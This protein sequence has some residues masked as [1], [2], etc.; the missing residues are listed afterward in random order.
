GAI[1]Q[2]SPNISYDSNTRPIQINQINNRFDI[3]TGALDDVS[4]PS[5]L[6]V[7]GESRSQ[8]SMPDSIEALSRSNVRFQVSLV[9]QIFYQDVERFLAMLTR[10]F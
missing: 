5:G 6:S 9:F 4:L 8:P 7:I 10:L 2:T 1:A 3:E